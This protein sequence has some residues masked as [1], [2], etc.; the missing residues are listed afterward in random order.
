MDFVNN[1]IKRLGPKYPD[2]PHDLYQV[3]KKNPSELEQIRDQMISSLKFR[4]QNLPNEHSNQNFEKMVNQMRGQ[5]I[6]AVSNLTKNFLKA[7]RKNLDE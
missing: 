6:S 1:S 5:D 7:T 3:P 4:M 2:S